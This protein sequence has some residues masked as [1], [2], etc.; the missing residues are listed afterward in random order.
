M[1]I[2]NRIKHNYISKDK[3]REKIKELENYIIK[4]EEE[5]CGRCITIG[6]YMTIKYLK[7]LL[8]EDIK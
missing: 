8:E 1:F 6:E 5:T 2:F 4:T 7:E 3:I